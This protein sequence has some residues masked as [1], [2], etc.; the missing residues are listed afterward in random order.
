MCASSVALLLCAVVFTSYSRWGCEAYYTETCAWERYCTVY[1]CGDCD[2][3]AFCPDCNDP[4]CHRCDYQDCDTT[5]TRRKCSRHDHGCQTCSE[6]HYRYG[7]CNTKDYDRTQC[8]SC[9]GNST[10]NR[11]TIGVSQCTCNANFAMKCA[12]ASA[13]GACGCEPCPV[14]STSNR[15]AIGVSQCTCNANVPVVHCTTGGACVC[16]PCP[17]NSTN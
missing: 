6:N 8:R 12:T 1:E 11:G 14:N 7:S 5:S 13:G 10:S 9:P 2:F 16:K 17:G 15:G 4:D 3:F